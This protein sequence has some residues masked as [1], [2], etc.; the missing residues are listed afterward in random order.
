MHSNYKANT[1]GG[2]AAIELGVAQV[3]SGCLLFLFLFLLARQPNAA[4][5]FFLSCFST[6]K[7]PG[8]TFWCGFQFGCLCSCFRFCERRCCCCCCKV[9]HFRR[10]HAHNF[11]LR[12]SLSTKQYGQKK[13]KRGLKKAEK[14]ARQGKANVGPT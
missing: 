8:N 9:C 13:E 5:E 12:L 7:R 10:A 6:V 1:P 14:T 3:E 2:A 4:A 11:C